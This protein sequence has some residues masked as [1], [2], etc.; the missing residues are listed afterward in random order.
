MTAP[1]SKFVS[2]AA[3]CWRSMTS[4]RNRAD[5]DHARLR[6]PTAPAPSTSEGSPGNLPT[7]FLAAPSVM[8]VGAPISSSISRGADGRAGHRS[9]GRKI[10]RTMTY[11]AAMPLLWHRARVGSSACIASRTTSKWLSSAAR[12]CPLPPGKSKHTQVRYLD[13]HEANAC[14][15]EVAR[16]ARGVSGRQVIRPQAHD[17][18]G[19]E[20]TDALCSGQG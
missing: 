9:C 6:P 2:S 3:P 7:H 18:R 13:I 16:R 19:E 15:R 14:E 20:T 8:S 10:I 1:L 17:G 5:R 12:H 11:I 4:C